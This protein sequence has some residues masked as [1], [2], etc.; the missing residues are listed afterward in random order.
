MNIHEHVLRLLNLINLILHMEWYYDENL[1]FLFVVQIEISYR[2]ESSRWDYLKISREL[3]ELGKRHFRSEN[4]EIWHNLFHRLSLKSN[5]EESQEKSTIL[6][7][8]FF[9]NSE[10]QKL[11]NSSKKIISGS[12]HHPVIKYYWHC[13]K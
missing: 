7:K 5:F 3:S 10:C 9:Y 2:I 8:Y 4:F 12:T 11:G 1:W 6:Q 13:I